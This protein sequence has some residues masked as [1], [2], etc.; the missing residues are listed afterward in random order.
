MAAKVS[1]RK[2]TLISCRPAPNTICPFFLLP[3]TNHPLV[4]GGRVWPSDGGLACCFWGPRLGEESKCLTLCNSK[5]CNSQT[6]LSAEWVA[7]PSSRASS[8]PRDQT[9]VSP[10]LVGRFFTTWEP[11]ESRGGCETNPWSPSIRLC[12]GWWAMKAE[13][14]LFSRIFLPQPFSLSVSR[15]K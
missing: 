11:K 5:D 2:S 1:S 12:G 8:Q 10:A 13:R 9:H 4:L 15:G 7:I 6:P 14:A 3:S